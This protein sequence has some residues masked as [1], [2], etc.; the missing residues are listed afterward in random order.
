MLSVDAVCITAAIGSSGWAAEAAGALG[1]DSDKATAVDRAVAGG[2]KSSAWIG[3]AFLPRLCVCG[4]MLASL[5]FLCAFLA[6]FLSGI[7]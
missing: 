4:L 6:F 7:A 2:D 5:A 3:C 1:D